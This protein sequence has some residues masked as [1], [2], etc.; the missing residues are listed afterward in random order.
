MGD[1][2]DQ[3]DEDCY[4]SFDVTGRV[5]ELYEEKQVVVLT[6]DNGG[7]ARIHIPSKREFS[8]L[9]LGK[10]VTI[11]IWIY[12]WEIDR[13]DGIMGCLSRDDARFLLPI[14]SV[15]G[16]DPTSAWNLYD[17]FLAKGKTKK[18]LVSAIQNGNVD[19]LFESER[20]SRKTAEKIII[21]LKNYKFNETDLIDKGENPNLAEALTMI[22]ALGYTK[23]DFDK[24]I[25]DKTVLDGKSASEILEYCIEKL[26]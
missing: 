14:M 22:T 24:V 1:N 21:Q 2:Y 7:F 9:N 10:S 16:V 13:E 12:R 3:T 19:E 11:A 17:T 23:V 4:A 20:I 5:E 15:S 26:Q 18:D 25:S 6:L 8:S